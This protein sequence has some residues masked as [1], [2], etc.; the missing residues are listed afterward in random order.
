MSELTDSPVVSRLFT[1]GHHQNASFILLLQNMLFK[2]KCN[3][4][5]IS[6]NAQYLAPFQ[7]PRE[8]EQIGIIGE[9]IFDKN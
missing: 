4:T 6:R 9:R 5:D 1:Q 3:N 2:G 7:S 8:G